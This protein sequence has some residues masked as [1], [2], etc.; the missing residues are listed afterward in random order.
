MKQKVYLITVAK[1]YSDYLR[2]GKRGITL[3]MMCDN[4][5]AK[6]DIKQLLQSTLEQEMVKQHLP[7]T[8]KTSDKK[9]NKR[10]E[11]R[12]QYVDYLQSV[13]ETHY[14]VKELTK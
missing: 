12:T 8:G 5:P 9:E 3:A 1:D 2:K 7:F 6:D 10:R 11:L 4:Y 13:N 14:I